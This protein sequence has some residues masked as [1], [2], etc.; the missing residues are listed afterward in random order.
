MNQ[1]GGFLEALQ[2]DHISDYNRETKVNKILKLKNST[3]S[4]LWKQRAVLKGIEI[5]GF[6]GMFLIQDPKLHSVAVVLSATCI[7]IDFLLAYTDWDENREFNEA[8]HNV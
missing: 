4:R 8:L 2:N 6:L 3:E 1:Q 7:A 5:I